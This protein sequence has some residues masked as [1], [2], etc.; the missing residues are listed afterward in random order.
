MVMVRWGS[1][2]LVFQVRDPQAHVSGGSQLCFKQRSCK[3]L[4]AIQMQAW[5]SIRKGHDVD[6]LAPICWET[7]LGSVLRPLCK[8][9]IRGYGPIA[10]VLVHE[11]AKQV[12]REVRSF[13]DEP[14]CDWKTVD[15]GSG[16]ALCQSVSCVDWHHAGAFTR[17][18]FFHA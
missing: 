1:S 6:A 3:N 16:I 2:Y 5:P 7:S 12:A 10:L 9:G 13:V 11:L 8:R 4:T 17:M 14:Q 15:S 18:F